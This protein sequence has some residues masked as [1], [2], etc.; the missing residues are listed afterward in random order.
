MRKRIY[1]LSGCI[2]SFFILLITYTL[3]LN[4]NRIQNDLLISPMS[5]I[6]Y[7]S[8][9]SLKVFMDFF[10]KN[11]SKK[12]DS[13]FLAQWKYF[14]WITE[15][16][17]R[18]PVKGAG[19][20]PK[21]YHRIEDTLYSRAVFSFILSNEIMN[22]RTEL[23]IVAIEFS[24]DNKE[25]IRKNVG[26]L[27]I[28]NCTDISSEV[29]VVETTWASIRYFSPM[30]KNYPVYFVNRLSEEI[31]LTDV[32]LGNSGWKKDIDTVTVEAA[33]E[34]DATLN[35]RDESESDDP[36]VVLMR[37]LYT[38]TDSQGNVLKVVQSGLSIYTMGLQD[39]NTILKLKTINGENDDQSH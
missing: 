34:Y 21:D 38:F 14:Y 8:D 29:S 13:E 10:Y 24:V 4:K 26:K 16:G 18:I 28:K 32:D 31:T 11:G 35:I 36:R 30:L 12:D 25:Y 33:S 9:D 37:P 27:M 39:K 23:N 6:V 17:D 3:L 15:D 20:D 7:V 19:I 1:V 2:I 5:G 22:G